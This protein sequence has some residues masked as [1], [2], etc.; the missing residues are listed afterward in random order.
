LFISTSL[1]SSEDETDEV[2]DEDDEEEADMGDE[3]VDEDTVVLVAVLL[4]VLAVIVDEDEL[5]RLVFSLFAS[6]LFAV[7][8]IG[9]L[10]STSICL[11]KL[12][13]VLASIRL[14]PIATS[15]LLWSIM[16]G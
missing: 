10:L 7:L 9:V 6:L 15:E 13:L 3:V 16:Y 12:L 1:D 11:S 8:L 2:E 14:L 4:A 5:T